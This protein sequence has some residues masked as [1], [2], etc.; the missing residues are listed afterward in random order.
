MANIQ[1]R[2]ADGPGPQS[3]EDQRY[4]L[5]ELAHLKGLVAELAAQED[6]TSAASCALIVAQ[7]VRTCVETLLAARQQWPVGWRSTLDALKAIDPDLLGVAEV[8]LL[9][10]DHEAVSELIDRVSCYAAGD[11]IL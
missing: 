9:R 10:A 2:Y 11:T 5:F 8:A 7:A 3:A 1:T 4:A 6:P